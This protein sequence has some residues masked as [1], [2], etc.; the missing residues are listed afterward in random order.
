MATHNDQD[1][2][3]TS[4]LAASE[5]IDNHVAPVMT[6][7]A[8]ISGDSTGDAL[9]GIAVCVFGMLCGLLLVV[10]TRWLYLQR[11]SPHIR[12]TWL[13]LR[14]RHPMPV[15]PRVTALS[16]THLGISRT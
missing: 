9:L 10:V 1:V 8:V 15:V 2:I 11:H 13:L 16:L 14:S 12:G 4:P 5:L 6:A 3:G 7:A